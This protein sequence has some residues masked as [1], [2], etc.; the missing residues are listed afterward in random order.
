MRSNPNAQCVV[1]ALV[2]RARLF[3]LAFAAA[4]ALQRPLQGFN[5]LITR[6]LR[7]LIRP[8]GPPLRRSAIY[9]LLAEATKPLK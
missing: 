6:D 4:S 7:T 9:E 8:G 3:D 1:K 2:P 5:A